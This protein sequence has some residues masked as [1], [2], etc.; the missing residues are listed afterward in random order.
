MRE[1][2]EEIQRRNVF[3]VALVYIIVA[4]ISMQVVDVMF[5]A[6]HIPD[7]VASA[8][9]VL[10][11]IGFPIA[12]I[13]A[14]AFEMTPDG[15]KKESEID[16][17]QSIAP[18]TGR[19]LNSLIVV[20]LIL[21]VGFL[22]ADKFML[23]GDDRSGG[24]PERVAEIRPSIAVLPFV[25]MSDDKANEYFS[26]GLAEEL[27]NV[28][29]KIPQLH[30]AG[31]T[32]S[33]KFKNTNED[34]RIIGEQ[35]NVAHVLEGS[36][37]KSGTKLRI[38]AQLI[39]TESGYH[40]WSNTYDRELT[41]I[42]AVQ[43][44]ITANVV[45]ALKITL[46][47]S[48]VTADRSTTNL[49]AYNLYLQARYF[50]EHTGTENTA[51][52]FDALNR[53]IEIDPDYLEAY[54]ALVYVQQNIV[55][56]FSGDGQEFTE[57]FRVMREY[58]EK[59]MQID[60]NSAIAISAM[61]NAKMAADWDFAAAGQHFRRAFELEPNNVDIMTSLGNY[62]FTLGRLDEMTAILSQA[63]ELDPLSIT[64]QRDLG[65]AHRLAGDLEKARQ[66]YQ[67]VLAVTPGVSRIN[68]RLGLVYLATGELDKAAAA[69]EAEP[70]DWVRDLGLA[71]LLHRKGNVREWQA[72]VKTYEETYGNLN[73]F[74][75][76]EIYADAGDFES[77]FHWLDVSRE[78]HDP[79]VG[80]LLTSQQLES[81]HT[82]PRWLPYVK[83]VGLAD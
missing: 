61:G 31:R 28:L 67:S 44:E 35:L 70:I 3:R 5:P 37:R 20:A 30:V 55:S 72:Q 29:A 43:D 15:L 82:D 8:V 36:V 62:F 23:S 19:K 53:A 39:D 48:G 71:I 14:W 27:L 65:D 24:E 75:L 6:L 4:W 66:A 7:W 76:A 74:Q 47:G 42:F 46:L 73:A 34:L 78:V 45:S 40:L 64:I 68:G 12:L 38:T 52:A 22:L 81:L 83:S 54:A 56:G 51:R 58:A 10:L 13:F 11:L 49:E 57:G 77:A 2:F 63:R 17:S 25:N 80:G 60:A 26:D 16:R 69:F 9:A 41:D 59:A 79:G 33:F 50:M 1:F 18:V 21:A 32:S